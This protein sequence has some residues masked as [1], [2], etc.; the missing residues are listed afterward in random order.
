ML[1]E[2]LPE[3]AAIL[4]YLMDNTELFKKNRIVRNMSN[5]NNAAQIY[6]A[7]FHSKCLH[8]HELSQKLL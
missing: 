2:N 1:N 8:C 6:I 3:K 7:I 4:A 5:F